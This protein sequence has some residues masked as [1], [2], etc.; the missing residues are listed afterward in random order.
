MENTVKQIFSDEKKPQP[1]IRH[2]P[3][4]TGAG[5]KINTARANVDG[6][7][8]RRLRD[9]GINVRPMGMCQIADRFQIMLK[10]VVHGDQ[11]DFNQLRFPVDNA[12]K[13]LQIN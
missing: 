13:I 8:T 4:E 10:A 2:Q 3:L 9:V 5:T 6:S 12:L 1:E 7:S 11:R